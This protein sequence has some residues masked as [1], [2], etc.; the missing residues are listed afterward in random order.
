MS[1]RQGIQRSY[2][3]YHN[4]R[5]DAVGE[6]DQTTPRLRAGRR[7]LSGPARH[8]RATGEEG[9]DQSSTVASRNMER[10]MSDDS[11]V[12]RSATHIDRSKLRRESLSMGRRRG[13]VL[14]NR[15]ERSGSFSCDESAQ[16]TGS[17]S[18]RRRSAI[19]DSLTGKDEEWAIFREALSAYQ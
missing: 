4:R 1:N 6:T 8:P 10:L 13:S 11:S 17:V 16:S 15:R 18:S 7:S 14:G 5:V 9:D 19:R 3:S 12:R 2:G